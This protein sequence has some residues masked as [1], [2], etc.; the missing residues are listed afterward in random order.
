MGG[1]IIESYIRVAAQNDFRCNEHQGGSL[2][3][4]D[5]DNIPQILIDQANSIIAKL[6]NYH[7]LY[8]LDFIISNSGQPYLLEGNIGPG[9][10]WNLSVKK[11]ELNAKRFIRTIVKQ[12]RSL[13]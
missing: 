3:Y 9:L 4:L 10:D 13:L 2:S 8:S 1:K 5:I 6:D 7:S 12:L 11:E